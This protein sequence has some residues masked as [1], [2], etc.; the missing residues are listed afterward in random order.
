MFRALGE[1]GLLLDGI[2]NSTRDAIMALEVVRGA[3]GV[4][5]DFRWRLANLACERV[6]GLHAR[7]LV[8]QTLR[9][10]MPQAGNSGLFEG[11]V[12]VVEFTNTF[13][14]EWPTERHG[15]EIWLHVVAVRL[16]DG[17]AV[18]MADVTNRIRATRAIASREE[19]LRRILE[20]VI[21]G[22]ITIDSRGIIETFN[23]AAESIFGY[24]ADEA[25]GRSINIL[26]LESH[27]SRYDQYLAA[28]LATRKS[29][30]IGR[31]REVE[32]VR[33]DGTTFSCNLAVSEMRLGNRTLFISVVRDITEHKKN[34]QRLRFLASRDPLTGLA[35]TWPCSANTLTM[36]SFFL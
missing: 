3:S 28:Y 15:R 9:T 35:T 32:A 11:L 18:T 19:R 21:D 33:K 27:R 17:V 30:V 10:V 14:I 5:E 6:L 36:I 16:A 7:E 25:L 23:R 24:G 13:D 20:T 31:G 12:S 34:E 2:L 22:I 4:V 1:S 29:S 8:G 26:M